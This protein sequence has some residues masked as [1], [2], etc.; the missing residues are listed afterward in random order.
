MSIK[1]FRAKPYIQDSDKEWILEKYREI[2]DTRGLI[3]GKYVS[4]FEEEVRKYVGTKHAIAVSSCGVGLE[5]TLRATGITG[6]KFIVPTQ[7]YPASVSC[8]IR[9]GNIPIVADVDERT[10]CLSLDIIKQNMSDD[11]CGVVH[12]HMAGL[13]TPEMSDIKEYCEDN[14]LFL[15]TDDAHSFGSQLYDINKDHKMSAGNIGNVG[16][17][18]FYPSKIITTAEGGMITTNDDEL[19]DKLRILRSHGVV[20]NDVEVDGLDYGVRCEIP[21]SN[22]RMTEFNAVLGLSQI[23]HIDEWI[24]RRNEI[25]ELYRKNLEDVEWLEL[26][27]YDELIRQTWWQYIVKL[28]GEIDRTEFLKKLLDRGV[29]TG[30]AYWPACNQQ[31]VFKPYVSEYGCPIA[32][33]FLER[34]FSLPMYIELSDDDIVE[35]C[36]I[37]K[38]CK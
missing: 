32:D 29:Q 15:L 34:H 38:S 26:P 10:Q 5:I 36:N 13:I 33:E 3:Q 6:R 27:L 17:F 11:V 24:N 12:V 19:A 2:L 1:Y 25:S 8:I 21:S 22:Y 31:E 9:S 30:N 23:K 20:G 4:Q 28:N 18:S 16:V 35:I 14:G 7:T 37:V